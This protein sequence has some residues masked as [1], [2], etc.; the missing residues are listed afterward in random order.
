MRLF[1][2][3]AELF[4]N[5]S[6]VTLFAG[7]LLLFTSSGVHS[8]LAIHANTLFWGMVPVQVQIVTL[9]LFAG[10]LCGA[11]LAGP[12]LRRIEK[13]NVLILGIVGLGGAFA[14]PPTARLV[15]FL[16][17]AP[18]ARRATG[19]RDLLRRGAD[20]GGRNRLRLDDGR[21]RRLARTSFQRTARRAVFRRLG[22]C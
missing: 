7:A 2:E 16:P 10:L 4:R 20:G 13:R 17:P 21:R 15:G 22:L 12:L 18:P 19:D 6:F 5:R 14:L 1:R 11:P 8:T 9:A 3:I